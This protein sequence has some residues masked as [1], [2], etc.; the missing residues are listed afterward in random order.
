MTTEFL[1][2]SKVS[3]KVPQRDQ[4]PTVTTQHENVSQSKP[5]NIFPVD[6]QKRQDIASV[7]LFENEQ[8][9]TLDDKANQDKD[10]SDTVSELNETP[11]LVLR[12]LEFRID[13]ESGRTVITVRDTKTSKVIRQIP[14]EHLLEI[15][16]KLKQ[17][18]ENSQ[19][20]NLTKGILFT[21]KT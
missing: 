7:K 16:G 15:S 20:N 12:N 3:T 11:Q 13:N 21:S 5:V 2:I 9:Q 19:A 1:N 18:Q 17:L 10:I 4:L 14:S 8:T 6:F